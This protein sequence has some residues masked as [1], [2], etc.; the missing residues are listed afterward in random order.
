MQ[1]AATA[2]AC[3]DPTCLKALGCD[4]DSDSCMLQT[5]L[6]KAI[7]MT[8]CARGRHGMQALPGGSGNPNI[9]PVL[10]DK[11]GMVKL[12]GKNVT[13]QILLAERR[14]AVPGPP[15]P[16][17]APANQQSVA[18]KLHPCACCSVKLQIGPPSSMS[19][20]NTCAPVSVGFI[21]KFNQR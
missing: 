7:T 6:H 21:C 10:N 19:A 18:D 4:L 13:S 12:S 9:R 11:S 3:G 2:S 20:S 14:V 17:A 1:A 5:R 8:G 15:P 16:G